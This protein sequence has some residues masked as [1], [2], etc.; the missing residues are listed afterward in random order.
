MEKETKIEIY[1]PNVSTSSY[2][3]VDTPMV[4]EM[5]EK[6][7]KLI[8]SF[9][10]E[11]TSIDRAY[12]DTTR[13]LY[14]VWRLYRWRIYNELKNNEIYD[15]ILCFQGDILINGEKEYFEFN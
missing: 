9:N 4:N 2:G 3:F 5:K 6:I 12:N 10:P 14:K 13:I 8:F 1:C 15:E 11:D 7:S